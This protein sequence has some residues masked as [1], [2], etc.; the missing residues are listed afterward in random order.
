MSY[1]G[2]HVGIPPGGNTTIGAPLNGF[3]LRLLPP[4]APA[5]MNCDGAV[6]G[7]DIDDFVAALLDEW[8]Y[9]P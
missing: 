9:R 4:N 5:D 8:A 1:I 6:D 2:L 3:Q 7:A